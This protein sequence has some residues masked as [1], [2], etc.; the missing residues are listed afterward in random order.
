MDFRKHISGNKKLPVRVCVFVRKGNKEG[1]I[2]RSS[3]LV[4]C[5]YGGLQELIP[6]P[7]Y[8]VIGGALVDGVLDVEMA[9]VMAQ[10]HDG[11]GKSSLGRGRCGGVKRKRGRTPVKTKKSE[12]EEDVCF[13]CFDGGN[14]MLCDIKMCLKAY[15]LTCVNHDEAFFWKKGRWNCATNA[16][17]SSNSSPFDSEGIMTC[18]VDSSLVNKEQMV[19]N[20]GS[21]GDDDLQVEVHRLS[22]IRQIPASDQKTP[23]Q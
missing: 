14:L 15:H 7:S 13:I 6:S 3:C 19:D 20:D 10:D 16:T 8:H 17:L 23:N 1:I 9:A 5:D 21:D 18:F 22:S 12:E 4:P 2:F 11:A